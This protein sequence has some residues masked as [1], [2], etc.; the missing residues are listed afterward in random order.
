MAQGYIRRR[1]LSTGRTAYLGCYR[2]P[3]DKTRT[4]Q[5]PKKADAEDWVAAQRVGIRSGTWIDPSGTA[6]EPM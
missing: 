2:G 5:F 1:K 4:K 6:P 3:D